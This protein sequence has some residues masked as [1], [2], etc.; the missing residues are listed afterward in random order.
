[1][2]AEKLNVKDIVKCLIG[3]YPINPQLTPSQFIDFY[4]AKYQEEFSS[5]N[6]VNGGVF[7]QLLVIALVRQ[8]IE[9]VYVQ[10]KLAFVPNVILDIVLYNRKTPITISAKTTLRE[11]WKQADLEAMATKYVH[12]NAKCYVITL[13]E[14]EVLARRKSENSYMGIDDF[15]LAHTVEFDNLLDELKQI[16]ISESE[17][18]KIITTDERLYNKSTVQE[19]YNFVF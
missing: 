12:R 8:G 17:S 10:A 11:R 2:I 13:S 7:E 18:I 5:N 3:K 14:K 15:V 19:D 4:W 6:S 16:Q 9:P 1:M